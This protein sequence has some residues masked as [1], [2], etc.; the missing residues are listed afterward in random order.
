M[1]TIRRVEE[2]IGKPYQRIQMGDPQPEVRRKPLAILPALRVIQ[3][4]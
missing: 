1:I 4:H 3:I 2:A